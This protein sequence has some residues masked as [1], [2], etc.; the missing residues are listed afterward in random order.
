MIHWLSDTVKESIIKVVKDVDELAGAVLGTLRDRAI[1]TIR[2]IRSIADEMGQATSA[3]ASS[4]IHMV[5]ELGGD[6]V[7][8]GADLVGSS[9]TTAHTTTQGALKALG[10]TVTGVIT[11]LEEVKADLDHAVVSIIQSVIRNTVAIGGDVASAVN[12]TVRSTVTGLTGTGV[13][14]TH[15][16]ETAVSTA[17]KTASEAGADVGAVAV[18]AVNGA[19]KAVEVVG[20]SMTRTLTTSVNMAMDT[21]ATLGGDT[22]AK[23]RDALIASVHGA[24]EVIDRRGDR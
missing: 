16:I 15:A 17:M 23:V 22:T 1:A 7:T 12:E 20:G 24:K 5:H 6:T 10:A 18:G 13:E 8:K 14:V 19:L 3:I 11:G 4:T 21:A 2:D 9:I